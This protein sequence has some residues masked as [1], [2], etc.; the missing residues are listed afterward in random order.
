[1]LSC[2]KNFF[3]ILNIGDKS[4]TFAKIGDSVAEID[5]NGAAKKSA[6]VADIRRLM[7]CI[8]YRRLLNDF[9]EIAHLVADIKTFFI[10]IEKRVFGIF[11]FPEMLKK[12]FYRTSRKVCKKSETRR[13]R[14]AYAQR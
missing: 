11:W 7:L 13:L 12:P 5:W 10:V 14:P 3:S 8:K 9:I 6:T 4:A 1:M 2:V